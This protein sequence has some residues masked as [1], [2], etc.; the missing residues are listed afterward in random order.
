MISLFINPAYQQGVSINNNGTAP[1]NSAILDVSSTTQGVLI[2][3]MTTAEMN[4]ISAPAVGLQVYDT[5]DD[6]IKMWDGS[7]WKSA[8]GSQPG[9]GSG[10]YP[11]YTTAG[12]AS[13]NPTTGS[14]VGG[15]TTTLTLT[16][17][18]GNIRWQQS[19]DNI[20]FYD[21]VG[22]SNPV[23]NATVYGSP[24]YFVAQVSQGTC[25]TTY[26]NVVTV[27]A[28]G[29]WPFSCASYGWTSGE[30]LDAAIELANG[31]FAM[32]GFTQ[33]CSAGDYDT[34]IIKS[35]PA[36]HIVWTRSI[37]GT[38]T[39]V[40]LCL[41]QLNDGGI[42]VAGSTSTP[43]YG[44][45]GND[46]Y[47]VK[48][49]TTGNLLWT[50][51]LGNTG[52]EQAN[53][54]T[55]TTDGGFVVCGYTNSYG[56]GSNDVYIAKFDASGNL[57]WT[58][59]VGGGSSDYAN[60]VIE[61]STG[62]LVVCGSSQSF[63]LGMEDAYVIKLNS[64]GTVQWT[65]VVGGGNTDWGRNVFQTTDGGFAIGGCTKTPS[66][67]SHWDA[68]AFKLNSSGSLQ[69]CKYYGT[70]NNEVIYSAAPTTGDGFIM[71]GYT[72]QPGNSDMLIVKLDASGNLTWASSAGSSQ[73]EYSYSVFQAADGAYISTGFSGSDGYVARL[74]ASGNSCCSA[75]Q[76]LS[77]STFGSQI[78]GG[79]SS[80][81]GNTG[82]GGI[83]GTCGTKMIQCD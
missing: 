16:G 34:W 80:S 81:G 23:Y 31:C 48:F 77:T 19:S 59:T 35:D 69:W 57:Q 70:T 5:D 21:I 20:Y 73:T 64:T 37:G 62:D 66:G 32:T 61:T 71:S 17:Y 83:L 41:T 22:A 36:G 39:E 12:T 78:T 52:T 76:T 9:G 63:G 47:I 25:A 2:P 30:N 29:C 6:C 79:S 38:G 74:D 68:C 1:D 4:A 49:D 65:S 43:S 11:C 44:F 60:S 8:C 18:S 3:R 13:A 50:K 15:Y 27:Y 33:T 54:I 26:S 55:K 40:G 82:S 28:T 14:C 58:R 51:S 56:A 67:G 42:V 24:T 45:G 53:G 46:M 72:N 10:S 75:S 7:T